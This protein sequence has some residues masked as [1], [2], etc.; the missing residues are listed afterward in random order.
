MQNSEEGGELTIYDLLWEKG[1]HK[2][3][4]DNNDYIL[5]KNDSQIKV[6]DLRSFQI[7]PRAGDVL[8]FAGG[9]IYHRVEQIKGTSDRITYGGFINFSKD[10]DKFYLW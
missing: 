3:Y 10:F 8:V 6:S 9:D 5:D 7:R 4:H 2:D 1:Q